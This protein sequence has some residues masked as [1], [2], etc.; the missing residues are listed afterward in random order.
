MLLGM[1]NSDQKH[2]KIEDVTLPKR[3]DERSEEQ[4]SLFLPLHQEE[5][6]EA[7]KDSEGLCNYLGIWHSRFE[8]GISLPSSV[9]LDVAESDLNPC[10]I[11]GD[12][13]YGVIIS[14]DTISVWSM[15]NGELFPRLATEV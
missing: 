5:I 8:E 11:H 3:K 13:Y 2:V 15:T 1:V 6:N 9:D 7:W 10:V 14:T 4:G 12:V